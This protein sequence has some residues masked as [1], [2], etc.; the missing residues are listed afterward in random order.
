MAGA[1]VVTLVGGM[2]AAAA[3]PFAVGAVAAWVAHGRL[4][5]DATLLCEQ[6]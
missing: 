6:R 3:V 2:G 1:V 5:V 4:R